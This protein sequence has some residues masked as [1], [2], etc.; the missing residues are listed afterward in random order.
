MKKLAAILLMTSMIFIIPTISQ[1]GSAFYTVYDSTGTIN[2]VAW[3]NHKDGY[4]HDCGGV[5]TNRMTLK[6]GT[7]TS[8]SIY[9]T[10]NCFSS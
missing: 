2:T 9:L 3:F 10:F 1:A 7:V 6:R 4:N 5:Y 8:S